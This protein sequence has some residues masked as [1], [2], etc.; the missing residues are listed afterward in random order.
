MKALAHTAREHGY[1]MQVIEAVERVN[2]AQ[3]EVVFEKLQ[4][5]LGDLRGKIVTI[6]GLA[7]KPETDDM[8]EAPATVVISRL[9]D[10][11][12][13]VRAYDPVAMPECR[14]RMEG[15]PVYYAQTMYE[16]AEGA[17]AIALLTEWKELRMPDWPQLRTMMRGDVIVDGRNIFDKQE[18]T[19]AGFRYS[20]IGK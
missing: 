17:D 10:A 20:G 9:L 15:W 7:F 8:R 16:A 12:A 4:A 19:A 2:E 1:T 14:R 18:V 11:G 3:K 6:W 13:E 5:A